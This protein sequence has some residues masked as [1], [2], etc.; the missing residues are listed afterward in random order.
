MPLANS[1]RTDPF[2]LPEYPEIESVGM[3]IN[4]GTGVECTDTLD[5]RDLVRNSFLRYVYGGTYVIYSSFH[6][7]IA[8]LY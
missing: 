7:F 3:L 5:V 8:I 4:R 6:F 2:K 1:I